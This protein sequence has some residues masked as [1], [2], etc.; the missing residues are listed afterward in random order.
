[1]KLD[2]RKWE[3]AIVAGYTISCTTRYITPL[4]PDRYSHFS[5]SWK[6][7]AVLRYI[8]NWTLG[9][10]YFVCLGGRLLL[11][12]RTRHWWRRIESNGSSGWTITTRLLCCCCCCP[13][14]FTRAIHQHSYRVAVYVYTEQSHSILDTVGYAALLGPP[15]SN[16]SSQKTH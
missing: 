9:T 5:P 6:G 11:G 13:F 3:P 1:M 14:F 15:C 16:K 4:T 8:G 7:S 2:D 12:T 10:W